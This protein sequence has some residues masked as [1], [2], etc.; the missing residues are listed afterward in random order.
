MVK[1]VIWGRW[2][3]GLGMEEGV[4]MGEGFG[5]GEW[6]SWYCRSVDDK[7]QTMMGESQP[8]AD[9]SERMQSQAWP[10]QTR[11]AKKWIDSR[12][13]IIAVRS[14]ETCSVSRVGVCVRGCVGS[15]PN[16]LLKR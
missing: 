16:A 1:K 9:L 4:E 10:A 15:S 11:N 2:G 3:S 13:L 5:R 6:V 7:I 14:L 8:A 12:P